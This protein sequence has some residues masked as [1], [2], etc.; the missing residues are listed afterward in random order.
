MTVK[1]KFM[2]VH[3]RML[4]ALELASTLDNWEIASKIEENHVNDDVNE[5][6][7]IQRA[8]KQHKLENQ[9]A[10]PHRET[11]TGAGVKHQ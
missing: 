7:L 2:E 8:Y 11:K 10:R 5:A 3:A 9:L 4:L 1:A 6:A